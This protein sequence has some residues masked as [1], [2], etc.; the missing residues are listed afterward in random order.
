[1][2]PVL[3]INPIKNIRRFPR[4]SIAQA[5]AA[6]EACKLLHRKKLIDDNLN[7][8]QL[9]ESMLASFEDYRPG[10]MALPDQL[11]I[12][13]PSHHQLG[14]EALLPANENTMQHTLYLYRLKDVTRMALV[15]RTPLPTTDGVQSL[16]LHNGACLIMGQEEL[17]SLVWFHTTLGNLAMNGH[18]VLEE[19]SPYYGVEVDRTRDKGYVMVP[20]M[21]TGDI[22]WEVVR[23]ASQ[24]NTVLDEQTIWPLPAGIDCTDLLIWTHPKGNQKARLYE[25]VG[26]TDVT[27]GDHFEMRRQ[28]QERKKKFEQGEVCDEEWKD[29]GKPRHKL[30]PFYRRDVWLEADMSQTLLLGKRPIYGSDIFPETQWQGKLPPPTT[31][32]VAP[33]YCNLVL[34]PAGVMRDCCKMI[35]MLPELESALTIHKLTERIGLSMRKG[36]YFREATTVGDYE[37]LEVL[38]DSYLKVIMAKYVCQIEPI[39][40][41]EGLLHSYRSNL[42]SA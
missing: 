29:D 1:M 6:F 17:E 19:S 13:P 34:I 8:V 7:P 3:G 23:K 18:Q 21:P 41:K 5:V 12:P 42:V 31:R 14:L 9:D 2:P 40:D 11:I 35:P 15:T 24:G 28:R 16:L 39:L 22:D 30:V 10:V 38:G 25:V 4:K 27:L 32:F 37:R 33:E 20:L 36:S 26:T